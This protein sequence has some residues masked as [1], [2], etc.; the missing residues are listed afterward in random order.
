ML[1][2]YVSVASENEIAFNM[3][4]NSKLFFSQFF[5]YFHLNLNSRARNMPPEPNLKTE[6]ESKYPL[7]RAAQQNRID[8]V[9]WL[10]ENGLAQPNTKD[11]MHNT[12]LHLASEKDSHQVAKFLIK[13]G[14][15]INAKDKAESVP[16]HFA[17]SLEVAKCLIDN[18]TV[19]LW[20]YYLGTS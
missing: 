10:I 18:H 16:L 7:H 9:K 11:K 4:T 17:H 6:N 13:N 19:I 14:A 3:K 1:C 5:E 8:I 2:C 12:A 20:N 15:D